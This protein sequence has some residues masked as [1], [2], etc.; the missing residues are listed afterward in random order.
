MIN[1]IEV[2]KGSQMTALGACRL[3]LP[4]KPSGYAAAW[5]GAPKTLKLLP[6]IG[7]LISH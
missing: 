7:E 4:N 6:F 3:Y 5:S 1:I 2:K